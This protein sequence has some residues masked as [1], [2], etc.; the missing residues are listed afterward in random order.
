M[1][2]QATAIVPVDDL[3]RMYRQTAMSERQ[4]AGDL[5]DKV[6]AAR[7]KMLETIHEARTIEAAANAQETWIPWEQT[8]AEGEWL[9]DDEVTAAFERIFAADRHFE[10]MRAG[11]YT[12]ELP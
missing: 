8:I 11:K 7:L 1:A 2:T 9:T 6:K 3:E 5:A 12:T 4:F 10:E